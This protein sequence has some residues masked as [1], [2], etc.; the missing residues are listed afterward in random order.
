MDLSEKELLKLKEMEMDIFKS[1]ISVC[2]RLGLKYYIIAGTLIGAVRHKGFIPWDDDIDVAMPRE[3]YEIFVSEGQHYLPG[4]LFI[5]TNKTDPEFAFNMA[6]IRNSNTTFLEESERNCK[7][8]SGIFIDIFVLDNFPENIILQKMAIIIDK[9]LLTAIGRVFFRKEISKTLV[10]RQKIIGLVFPSPY[11]A[12]KLRER[13]V[14]SFSQSAL[15]QNFSSNYGEKE[16]VPWEWYG[17][18][19]ELEFEG[20]KV[21]APTKYEL[22]L[23]KIYGDYLKLPPVE[24]RVSNHGTDIID[25]DNGYL[26]YMNHE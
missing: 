3:D 21:I 8:N 11:T 25:L 14:K 24:K 23:K 19:V 12:V 6:K 4:H 17:K 18:G 15:T 1:F 16:I 7:I 9:V 10:A 13:F 22:L 5:Q 26:S 20:I 2:H